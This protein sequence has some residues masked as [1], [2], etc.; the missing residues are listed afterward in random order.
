[1]SKKITVIMV[2][3]RISRIPRWKHVLFRLFHGDA[4]LAR[5]GR[6]SVTSCTVPSGKPAW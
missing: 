6:V 5:K 3:Q 4:K 1:M 2:G